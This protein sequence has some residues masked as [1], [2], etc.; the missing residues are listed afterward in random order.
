MD[1]ESAPPRP[2][3]WVADEMAQCLER[4]LAASVDERTLARAQ[5]AL[6]LWHQWTDR[7]AVTLTR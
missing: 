2:E 5:Q 1:Q 3:Q 4:F 7:Y 6:E